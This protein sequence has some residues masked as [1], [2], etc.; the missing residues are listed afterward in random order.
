MKMSSGPTSAGQPMLEIRG[1]QV[2]YGPVRALDGIDLHLGEGEVL[3]VL[4][5]NGAGKTTLVRAISGLLTPRAGEIVLDGIPIAGRSPAD[6]ARRGIAHVPEGRELFGD[7]TV[8]EN[9]RMGTFGR[10][11]RA[12]VNGDLERIFEAMPRLRERATQRAG[13]LSGGEQQMLALG[14]AL[15]AD[16]RILLLDEPSLGL[17]P[18][19]VADIFSLLGQLHRERGLAMI[20]VEQNAARA[21]SLATR[22]MVLALGHVVL[23]AD[24]ATLAADGQLASSYLSDPTSS[25]SKET[26]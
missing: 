16:P 22:A 2:S 5:S 21:L 11:T 10:R 7:L 18:K 4:G 23:S 20:V 15:M 13:S 8:R 3:A 9:L 19:I 6:I 24:A 14:R 12:G 26:A 17:A 1:L 25:R